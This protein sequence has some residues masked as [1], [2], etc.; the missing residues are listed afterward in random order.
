[1]TFAAINADGTAGRLY[2]AQV[3]PAAETDYWK[4]ATPY[5]SAQVENAPPTSDI[6]QL[7]GGENATYK[8]TLSEAMSNSSWQSSAS[9]RRAR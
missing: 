9:A 6:L 3:G 1:M 8:V 4:P 5:M 7:L 2:G